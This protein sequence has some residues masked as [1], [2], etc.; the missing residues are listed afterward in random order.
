M[1]QLPNHLKKYKVDQNY[2]RYTSVDQATWRYILRQLKDYLGSHAHHC[3]LDGLDKT[4][5][6]EESI[7]RIEE[8]SQKLQKFGW[9]AMPVSGFIPPAAFMELQSLSIL[10]IA[11]DMRTI[12]HLLY[13]PAPDIV[14]E[15][16]GHAPIITDPEYAAYLKEYAQ[17]AKKAIMSKEDIEM[18]EA[19]RDLS[20]IK[21]NP[22]STADQVLKCE[23]RLK[24]ITLQQTHVSE[25]AEL[26]RMNWWTAEYGLIGDLE[27]PKIFGAG[28]L[29]S[30]GESRSCLQKQVIKK[31]LTVECIQQSYDITEPQPQLYVTPDFKTLT[32]VLQ[33]MAK[34]MAYQVGGE[35][36]L[37]KA[38]QAQSVNTIQ[39]DSGFQIS[40]ILCETLKDQSNQSIYLKFKGPTQISINETE[41][42]GQSVQHHQHGYS[43]PIGEFSITG[44]LVINSNIELNY[45]SGIKVSGQLKRI[46]QLNSKAQLL[47]L[48]HCTVIDKDKNILFEPAWGDYDIAVGYKVTSVFGGPADRIKFG[49]IDDF[50]AKQIPLPQFNDHQKKLFDKY[51]Q[52]RNFRQQL[53]V[54]DLISM[55]NDLLE[56]LSLELKSLLQNV[57]NDYSKEWLLVLEI[58]E[59]TCHI[60]SIKTN[61]TFE[62]I[63]SEALHILQ[64]LK[65]I[66]PDSARI[67]DNG[68]RLAQSMP[69]S[70]SAKNINL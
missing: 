49:S 19:I 9:S 54:V 52:V 39:L 58:F 70:Y 10:P 26:S 53:H 23:E 33:D 29:S 57:K 24:K 48:D 20:D 51:Q 2:E 68:I 38:L 44:Y 5:L 3:Y 66:T 27:N 56:R 14:H 1:N 7:P 6:N 28:L 43:V 46:N 13:T 31:P 17:V 55:P 64:S 35:V 22:Q 59:I 8:M 67:I 42:P 62:S 69:I 16:A 47:T 4:G 65:N 15:A 37:N 18:Y 45:K 30:L 36:G 40:G 21:E 50:V 12:D 60:C 25:A 34:S 41:I 32:K 61:D 11:S 63:K